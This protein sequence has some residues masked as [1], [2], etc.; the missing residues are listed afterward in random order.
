LVKNRSSI[1]GPILRNRRE[2]IHQRVILADCTG[3]LLTLFLNPPMVDFADLETASPASLP[4]NSRL[5][6]FGGKA[7]Q[8]RLSRAPSATCCFVR[9]TR[10]IYPILAHL[11][12][13]ASETGFKRTR[14]QSGPAR[15]VACIGERKVRGKNEDHGGKGHEVTKLQV[16][17]NVG[18]TGARLGNGSGRPCTMRFFDETG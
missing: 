1:V 16:R 3:F 17:I 4:A 12:G 6:L 15:F 9:I 11:C 7:N 2:I 5:L 13:P 10:C 14:R 8:V 18:R